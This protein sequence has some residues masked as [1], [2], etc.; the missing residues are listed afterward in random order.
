M[1]GA[2]GFNNTTAM[3]VQ[4][5][6]LIGVSPFDKMLQ[7]K[8]RGHMRQEIQQ[9]RTTIYPAIKLVEEVQGVTLDLEET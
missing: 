1:D 6:G 8:E 2:N 5:A 9:P 3:I 7:K 4:E